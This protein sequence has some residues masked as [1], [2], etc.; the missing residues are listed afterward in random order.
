METII[1]EVYDAIQCFIAFDLIT[2]DHNETHVKV[3]PK[4]DKREFKILFY[5]LEPDAVC[6][7][8][9]LENAMAGHVTEIKTRERTDFSQNK[10]LNVSM[11]IFEG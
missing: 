5:G 10:I 8:N 3:D 4:S 6:C 1:K 9:A 2:V 11:T 7:M